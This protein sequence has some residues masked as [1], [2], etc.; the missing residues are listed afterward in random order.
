VAL[1]RAIKALEKLKVHNDD[2]RTGRAWSCDLFETT[3]PIPGD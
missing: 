3:Q 1:L 2:Q